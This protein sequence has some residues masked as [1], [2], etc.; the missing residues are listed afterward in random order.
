[1]LLVAYEL[2]KIGLWFMLCGHAP[3]ACSL[4][5]AKLLANLVGKT[6]V[7]VVFTAR[8]ITKVCSMHHLRATKL[9][10]KF[11]IQRIESA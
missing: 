8:T 10:R 7:F 11:G 9:H 5:C 4:F 6:L 3:Q 2:K 1:M